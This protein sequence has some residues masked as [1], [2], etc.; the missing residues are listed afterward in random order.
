M[1]G[2]KD[3]LQFTLQEENPKAF[4]P[5]EGAGEGR[6]SISIKD[7]KDEG[8]TP[9]PPPT[10]PNPGE[11]AEKA[12]IK[13]WLEDHNI[14][15]RNLLLRTYT[16]ARLNEAIEDYEQVTNPEWG[17]GDRFHPRDRTAYFRSLLK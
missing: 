8:Y 9:H 5:E 13:A 2:K 4:S 6:G 16:A 12:E 15:C 10:P 3:G 1:A 7:D 11:E 14:G 17:K